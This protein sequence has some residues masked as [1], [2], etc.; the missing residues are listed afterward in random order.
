MNIWFNPYNFMQSVHFR[1]DGHRIIESFES[2][3]TIKGHLVQLPHS[4]QGHL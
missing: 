4:E 3:G 1:N 2:E